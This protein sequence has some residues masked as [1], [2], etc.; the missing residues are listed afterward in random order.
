[1]FVSSLKKKQQKPVI[2]LYSP[3][4]MVDRCVSF[5]IVSNHEFTSDVS[6]LKLQKHLSDDR[7]T[8]LYTGC[9]YLVT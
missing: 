3:D 9:K 4:N 6:P 1:M 7:W 8:Q 2:A 5:L